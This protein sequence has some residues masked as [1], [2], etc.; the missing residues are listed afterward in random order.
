[1]KAETRR[2]LEV[3]AQ[4]CER[5]HRRQVA[6]LPTE[7][8]THLGVSAVIEDILREELELETEDGA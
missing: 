3:L 2:R 8:L 7:G 4:D 6:G 1:M 5:A